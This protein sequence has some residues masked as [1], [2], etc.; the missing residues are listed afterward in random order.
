MSKATDS[1]FFKGWIRLR[2]F[3]RERIRIHILLRGRL[4]IRI[5]ARNT[6]D[7]LVYASTT[8]LWQYNVTNAKAVFIIMLFW[9]KI[10]MCRTS[11]NKQVRNKIIQ[12]MLHSKICNLT[13]SRG[14]LHWHSLNWEII[15][16]FKNT[17]SHSHVRIVWCVI[18]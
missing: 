4:R 9:S 3:L 2:I 12:W 6:D 13:R 17:I 7:T 16:Q 15:L 1:L 8:A 5:R 10:G 14:C 18:I 11:Q